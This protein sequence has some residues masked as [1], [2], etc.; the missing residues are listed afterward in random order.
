MSDVITLNSLN[1]G[2][3]C[4][5]EGPAPSTV[6]F[7][8]P[9]PEDEDGGRHLVVEMYVRVTSLSSETRE[10]IRKDMGLKSRSPGL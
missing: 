6:F 8:V 3:I 7:V 10:M 2:P 9:G 4:V 1:R 5:Q